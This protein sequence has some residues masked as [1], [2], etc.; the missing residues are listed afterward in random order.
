MQVE[1]K[2]EKGTVLFVRVPDDSYGF[3]LRQNSDNSDLWY[4][5]DLA[6]PNISNWIELRPNNW[7]LI[8]LASEV[9]EE[10]AKVVG[11]DYVYDGM[12]DENIKGL[13]YECFD[14]SDFVCQNALESFKSLMQ[15]LQVHEVNPFGDDDGNEFLGYGDDLHDKF[16]QAKERT[17]KFIVLFKPN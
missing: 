9:T 16:N 14:D 13:I 17:G 3:V 11:F 8:G 5:Q 15:H 4:T 7:Q 12:D 10:Q 1:H 2:T 6:V